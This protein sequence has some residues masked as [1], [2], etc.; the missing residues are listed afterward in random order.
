MNVLFGHLLLFRSALAELCDTLI[1]HG[2][3]F[4][5]FDGYYV[6]YS[7]KQISKEFD[8]LRLSKDLVIDIELKSDLGSDNNVKI[9]AQISLQCLKE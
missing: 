1:S 6:G 7:I 4:D 3:P 5:V 9:F 2:L 8:L